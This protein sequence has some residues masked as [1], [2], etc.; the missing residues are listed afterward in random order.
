MRASS[1]ALGTVLACAAL[2]SSCTNVDFRLGSVLASVR[3][4]ASRADKPYAAPG[5]TA[6]IEVLTYDGR[7]DRSRPLQMYWI[8]IVCINPRQDLYY[9]CFEQFA[10]ATIPGGG[11]GAGITLAP[12]V[13]LT[14]YLPSGST[15]SVTLPN[16]IV[17]SHP[18][19]E[20]AD[21]YGLAIA[22]NIACAGH[23]ELVERDSQNPQAVPF[24]CFDDNHTRLA[25]DQ[26]VIGFSRI[27]GY[28]TTRN[29]NPTITSVLQEGKPVDPAAGLVV[30]R[31]TTGLRRDC[32]DIKL[33]VAV[34]P[35]DQEVQPGG[36]KEE[37]WAAYFADIGELDS[38]SRILYDPESGK[39]DG[40][41]DKYKASNDAVDGVMFVVVHDNRGG[42]DWLK[43]P[44]HTK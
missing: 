5:E 4:L 19:V 17:T 25:P 44:I 27:Y 36:R 39:V 13:D 40:S 2:T 32:P 34:P 33:D 30:D 28:D 16:D 14:P 38:E 24:G 7:A 12:G 11:G 18:K 20:G 35:E 41:E 1:F 23:I 29:A 9:A 6:K 10:G 8:P 15:Y 3:I 42:A 22:F 37:I 21:P 43:L 31:C 26:Y